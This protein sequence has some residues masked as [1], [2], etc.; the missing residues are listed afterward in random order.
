MKCELSGSF[1]IA[2][3]VPKSYELLVGILDD[4]ELEHIARI[5][6]YGGQEVIPKKFYDVIPELGDYD[7]S[8][9][10]FNI[11]SRD[12]LSATEEQYSAS[13]QD[14]LDRYIKQFKSP[15]I[16]LE[17]LGA[18]IVEQ[19]KLVIQYHEWVENGWIETTYKKMTGGSSRPLVDTGHML[20]S[21]KYKVVIN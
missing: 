17:K 5:L 8:F 15:Y 19:M 18:T 20:N 21:I 11:P 13:W 7:T 10:I 12:F 4:P 1:K 6:I 9:D 2:V 14:T 16:A 3:D